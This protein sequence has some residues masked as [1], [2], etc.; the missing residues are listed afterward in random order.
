MITY[1]RRAFA[2]AYVQAESTADVSGFDA[3]RVGYL[4]ALKAHRVAFLTGLERL[5]G[6]R[7]DFESV[8]SAVK[9]L[10]MFLRSTLRSCVALRTPTDG[11]LEGGLIIRAMKHAGVEDQIT[12]DLTVIRESNERSRAAHLDILTTLLAAMLGDA[13]DRVVTEDEVRAIGVDPTPPDPND[14]DF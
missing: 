6:L 3:E 14:Y 2:L 10:A 1:D 7:V 8:P 13:A 5:F 12:S 11:Y 9:P 4:D